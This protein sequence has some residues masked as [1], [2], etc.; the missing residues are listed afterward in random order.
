MHFM[1]P[2]YPI[3]SVLNIKENHNFAYTKTHRYKPY[4]QTLKMKIVFVLYFI[5]VAKHFFFL[6]FQRPFLIRAHV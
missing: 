3:L 4:I 6:L 5:F 1:K 2:K